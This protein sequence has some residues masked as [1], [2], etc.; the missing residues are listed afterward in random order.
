MKRDNYLIKITNTENGEVKYFTKDNYVLVYIGASQGALA[1]IKS[2]NSR[3]FSK[4]KYEIVDGS[5]IKYK[6]INDI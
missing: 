6:D 4:F 2:G 5:E 3:D 1:G